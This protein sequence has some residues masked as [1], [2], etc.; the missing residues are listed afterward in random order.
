MDADTNRYKQLFAAMTYVEKAVEDLIADELRDGLPGLEAA[1]ATA[2]AGLQAA[3]EALSEPQHA[4]DAVEKEIQAAEAKAAEFQAKMDDDVLE[5]RVESR[6]WHSEW[7]E[8]ISRLRKK[9][10]FAQEQMQPLLL[11]RDEAKKVLHD[12]TFALKLREANIDFPLLADGG[13]TGAFEFF[14]A[15]MGHLIPVLIHG[16]DNPLYDRALQWL[17]HFCERTGYRTEGRISEKSDMLRKFW[18]DYYSKHQHPDPVPDGMEDIR[19]LQVD[20]MNQQFQRD[21]LAPRPAKGQDGPSQP[22]E[23][24]QVD[25]AGSYSRTVDRI[26]GQRR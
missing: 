24:R 3:A 4:L 5:T 18:D 14:Y 2:A 7:S 6:R 11:V 26:T 9:R 12:A 25:R 19:L 20:A 17:D 21:Q 23:W 22:P 13:Y 16:E 8:E 1:E 15:N 10:D